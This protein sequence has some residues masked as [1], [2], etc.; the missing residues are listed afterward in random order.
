MASVNSV[1]FKLEGLD[2]LQRF[3]QKL[4]AKVQQDSLRKAATFATTPLLRAT[5]QE[6]PRETGALRESLVKKVKLYRNS[7]T[8]MAMIGVEKGFVRFYG[9]FREQAKGKRSIRQIP[10]KYLHLVEFGSYNQRTGGRNAPNRFMER[11]FKRVEPLMIQRFRQKL[12][13]DLPK[14]IA[15]LK[16]KGVVRV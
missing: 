2:R 8:I 10:G 1:E 3:F 16:K 13:R 12:K 9:S 14:D 15:R 7:G 6:A 5:K 4:P 11:A